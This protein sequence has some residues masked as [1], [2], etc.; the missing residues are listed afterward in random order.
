MSSI[1]LTNDELR[2]LI[3]QRCKGWGS[4]TALAAESGTTQCHISLQAN[5]RRPVS[6]TLARFF[7]YRPV[8]MYEK[9][10]E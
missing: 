5:G 6:S 10:E 7:G 8:R 3:R 2:S 1:L 9:I 4:Q